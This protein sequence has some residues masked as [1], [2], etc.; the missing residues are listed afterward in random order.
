MSFLSISQTNFAQDLKNYLRKF[1]STQSFKTS[2]DTNNI[3]FKLCYNTPEI[4][5]YKFAGFDSVSFKTQLK[6]K[7]DYHFFEISFTDLNKSLIGKDER[8]EKIKDDIL[9][10]I[11]IYQ[12]DKKITEYFSQFHPSKFDGMPNKITVFLE[13]KSDDSSIQFYIESNLLRLYLNISNNNLAS[14]PNIN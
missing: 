12:K 13:D 3:S 6:Q 4:E 2:K 8:T 7:D 9:K 10:S 14:L 5:S 11:F 1:N